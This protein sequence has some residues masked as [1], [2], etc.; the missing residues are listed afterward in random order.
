MREEGG[1][2]EKNYKAFIK[3]TIYEELA[4][5]SKYQI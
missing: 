3:K 4:K 1:W 5:W 2:G